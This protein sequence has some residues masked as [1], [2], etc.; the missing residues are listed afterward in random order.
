L[1]P[2]HWL[3]SEQV[4]AAPRALQ[5]PLAVLHLPFVHEYVAGFAASLTV[6]HPK[7]SAGPVPVQGP[8]AEQLAFP[9]D[10]THLPVEHCASA[11]H[12]HASGV[13]RLG[14]PAAQLGVAGSVPPAPVR[15][16]WKPSVGPAAPVHAPVAHPA[17]L[18][19]RP[20]RHWPSLVHQHATPDVLHTAAGE[21]TFEQLPL[22]QT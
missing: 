10:G 9:A 8:P 18:L 19:H 1:L 21:V 14:T 4:H 2:G 7:A 11:L 12:V 22:A 17:Q 20:L 15:A 5:A 13:A 16:Q 6:T 3:S